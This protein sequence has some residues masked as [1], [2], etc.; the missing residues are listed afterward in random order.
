MSTELIKRI[1]SSILLI[2]I[3]FFLIIEGSVFFIIFISIC[4]FISIYEWN[5]MSKK[6]N[7]KNLVLFS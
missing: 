5:N 4:F 3:S 1:L 7:T 2:P 6:K